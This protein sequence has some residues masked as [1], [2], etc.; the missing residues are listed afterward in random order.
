MIRMQGLWPK[1]RAAALLGAGS[2]MV[3]ELRYVAG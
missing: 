3:H 1:V 2:I